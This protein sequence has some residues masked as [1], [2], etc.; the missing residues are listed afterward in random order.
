MYLNVIVERRQFPWGGGGGGESVSPWVEVVVDSAALFELGTTNPN[1][2]PLPSFKELCFTL[3]Y[4]C[5]GCFPS[6]F[7]S[8]LEQTV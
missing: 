3:H 5:T 1:P 8:I 6:E 7:L 4:F 2:I